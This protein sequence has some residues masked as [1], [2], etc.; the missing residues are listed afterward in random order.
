VNA[1]SVPKD[2]SAK[3]INDRQR[4]NR[5][6]IR[7]EVILYLRQETWAATIEIKNRVE[8]R[9]IIVFI[10]L[11]Y[12]HGLFACA[13]RPLVDA[14]LYLITEDTTRQHQGGGTWLRSLPP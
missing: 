3:R 13:S 12:P 7:E 1:S 4:R 8:M 2:V 14:A 5:P 11:F 6:R 9:N 10:T